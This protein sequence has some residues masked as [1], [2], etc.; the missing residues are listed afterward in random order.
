MSN[1]HSKSGI[2]D[3]ALPTALS[4]GD[5]SDLLTDVY[6]RL[7]QAVEDV[8]QN[9]NRSTE[10]DPISA[11]HESSTIIDETSIDNAGNPYYAYIDMDGARCL[12]VQGEIALT[13]D[14]IAVT[15]EATIQDDGTAPASCD[16]QDITNAVAGV[17]NFTASFMLLI[18]TPLPVK[19]VR[20][21]YSVAGGADDADFTCYIK[22]MY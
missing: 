4:D 12:G 19:Y 13:L 8:V 22:K 17:A 10:V 11:H 7:R 3:T 15:V 6:G 14:T 5:V 16:Y 9:A 1:L 21:A 2:V 20:I 18:D